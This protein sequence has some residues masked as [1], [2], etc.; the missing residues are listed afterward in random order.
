MGGES[1]GGRCGCST[2]HHPLVVQSSLS[3]IIS[4][5]HVSHIHHGEIC[6]RLILKLKS[7]CAA[8]KTL[9]FISVP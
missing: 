9:C 2:H 1:E 7:E 5:Q 8:D 3:F 6:V 4:R